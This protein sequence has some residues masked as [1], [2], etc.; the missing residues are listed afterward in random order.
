MKLY[1]RLIKTLATSPFK[2]RV[3]PLDTVVTQW[4]VLPG[5]LDVFGHMN[6]GRYNMVMDIA[7]LDFI[8]RLGMLGRVWKH[9]WI[10]PV[11]SAQLDFRRALKPFARYDIHTRLCYW[12][13]HWFYFKQ[14][15][16]LP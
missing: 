12:D 6:N 1:G 14:E 9:R 11:G 5:D 4:R 7:R 13:E 2:E 16:M 10:V 8:A 3:S 15:F